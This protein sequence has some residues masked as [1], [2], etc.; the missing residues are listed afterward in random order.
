MPRDP[1]PVFQKPAVP[2]E[3]RGRLDPAGF[4][5]NVDFRMIAP[6]PELEFFLAHLWVIR[7]QNI[8]GTYLSAEVMH[9]PFVDAFVAADSDG[10]QGT[11]RGRRVY[12]ASGSGRIVGARFRPGAFRCFWP[13]ELSNLQDAVMPLAKAFAAY[14]SARRDS[15][16]GADDEAAA[17]S[18]AD[19]LL[20][21]APRRD[22][23]VAL[24]NA[25]IEAA[26]G[27]RELTSV[28]AVAAAF[29]RSER[30]VQQLFRD[31]L[32]IGLKWFLQRQRLLAAAERIRGGHAQDWADLAY[33][34]GYSS[35]QH[36]ITDFRT[37]IGETPRQYRARMNSA[38]QEL[39]VRPSR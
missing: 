2:Y 24:I 23:N 22:D 12:R 29:N 8:E 3:P 7:W 5:R 27:D 18:L 39:S 10:I 4:E 13:G 17:S 14:D 11:F 1:G 6:P 19:L 21:A 26:E 37:V 32:G 36:F 20:T 16:I 9:R 30:W 15:I 38:G 35:Q 31:Y 28:A 25:I 33:E 34:L